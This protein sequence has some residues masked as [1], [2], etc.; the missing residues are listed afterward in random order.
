MGSANKLTVSDNQIQRLLAK[1][2]KKFKITNRISWTD[3]MSQFNKIS[4]SFISKNK[5]PKSKKC[6]FGA[7]LTGIEPNLIFINKKMHMKNPQELEKTVA[8]EMA[9]IK[10]PTFS[11]QRIRKI[12]DRLIKN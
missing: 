10:H 12:T 8:H 2:K 5:T 11:E 7:T 1:W 9:H 4:D 3:K 6:V